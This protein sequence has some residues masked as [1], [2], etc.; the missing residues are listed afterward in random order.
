M[1]SEM[2]SGLDAKGDETTKGSSYRSEAE[3]MRH[4][5]Q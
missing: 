3:P 2:S 1:D 4:L 5:E